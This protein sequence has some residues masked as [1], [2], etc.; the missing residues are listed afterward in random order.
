MPDEYLTVAEF[1]E[2]LKLNLQKIY[3]WIDAGK[4]PNIRT[5]AGIAS[6]LADFHARQEAAK[7]TE[8]GD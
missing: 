3:N 7:A 5:G 8:P 6:R 4:P 2:L 1:A